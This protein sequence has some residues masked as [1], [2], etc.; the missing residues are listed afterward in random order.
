[1][2]AT[3]TCELLGL[4]SSPD[5]HLRDE[6]AYTQLAE[7]ITGGLED[8]RLLAIGEHV[9]KLFDD[10]RIQARSFAALVLAEIV[11]RDAQVDDLDPASIRRWLEAFS[12]W[13]GQEEDLRGFD[14]Q[15]GWLHAVAHGADAIAAFAGSRHLEHDDLTGLLALARDR[16]LRSGTARFADHEDDRVALAM[17]LVLARHELSSSERVDWLASVGAALSTGEPGP[18]PAWVSNTLHTLKALYVLADRGILRPGDPP[19]LISVPGA[20]AVT[21]AIASVLRLVFRFT[22]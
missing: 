6:V 10:A 20:E 7:R 19:V 18:V 17:S 8:G 22:G 11:A 21:A 4:L 1:M 12:G 3:S 14:A 9:V 15:L 5:P 2:P 16:V 13:Y